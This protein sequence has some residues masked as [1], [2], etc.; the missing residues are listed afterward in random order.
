MNEDPTSL[1]LAAKLQ[2]NEAKT[3]LFYLY[4]ARALRVALLRFYCIKPEIKN[5]I[6]PAMHFE[7][8]T[9]D[10]LR[11]F[12]LELNNLKSDEESDFIHW[13]DEIFK[14]CLL[15]KT[16]YYL[17]QETNSLGEK[18]DSGLIPERQDERKII[19]DNLIFKIKDKIDQE[20]LIQYF[21]EKKTFKKIAQ[22]PAINLKNKDAVRK[23]FY[24]AY[25]VLAEEIQAILY[26]RNIKLVA[27]EPKMILCDLPDNP[28]KTSRIDAENYFKKNPSLRNQ[29]TIFIRQ[30][31]QENV[32]N[33]R[34]IG[35]YTVIEELARGGMSE[36]FLAI[37]A[38]SR[39]PV[40]L[41]ILPYGSRCKRYAIDNLEQEAKIL[42]KLNHSNITPLYSTGED[43]N[44]HFIA[45]ALIPG[46]SLD[47]ILNCIGYLT[48]PQI[49]SSTVMDIISKHPDFTRLNYLQKKYKF[50]NTI[51]NEDYSSSCNKPYIEFITEVFYKI[52]DSINY[53][54][55]QKIY[56]GDLKLCHIILSANGKPFVI[57]F[58]V[59]KDTEVADSESAKNIPTSTIAY[60][61]PG[62][63]KK[64]LVNERLDIRAWGI[65]FRECINLNH[66]FNNG[67]CFR[68]LN[69]F[70]N[71]ITKF[72]KKSNQKI[73]DLAFIIDKCLQNNPKNCYTNISDLE[74]DLIS[75]MNGNLTKTNLDT[76]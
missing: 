10:A 43:N 9:Q 62:Q 49:E 18:N 66:H 50:Q 65:S 3:K 51:N 56:H 12:S 54:H 5:A 70:L 57:D 26:L 35:D 60:F 37:E 36:V 28:I 74:N 67:W 27:I 8:L 47:K 42:S 6:T 7:S 76:K 33:G 40:A 24:R 68:I 25:Q 1:I 16:D 38:T 2:N 32:W 53:A 21:F 44:I 20:I 31:T 17:S 72:R 13:L 45:M 64:K 15:E 55:N 19:I 52:A 4:R 30:G 58:G 75:F 46:I 59:A 73:I 22:D 61:I 34:K 69:V 39:M 29:V 48:M 63:L 23:R 11:I 41:K 14:N 71:S